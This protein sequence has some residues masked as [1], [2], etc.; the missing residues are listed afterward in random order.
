MDTVTIS[1]NIYTGSVHVYTIYQFDRKKIGH[2]GTEITHI[3]SDY[4]IYN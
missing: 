4:Q 2:H 3:S 1:S